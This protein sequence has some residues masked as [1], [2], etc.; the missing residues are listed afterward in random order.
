V[1]LRRPLRAWMPFAGLSV[2]LVIALIVSASGNVMRRD[3]VLRAP[4]QGAVALLRAPHR[5]CQGP[6]MAGASTQGVAI[7]G[8][9][10]VGPARVTV[11]VEDARSGASLATGHITATGTGQYVADLARSV[12]AGRR[13]RVCL[14]TTLNT[15]ELL[16][17]PAADPHVVMTG[18]KRGLEFSLALLNDRH[19]LLGS[20][21]TAFS[22]AA[23]FKP[24]W[25]GGWTFWVL[26]VALLATFGLAGFAIATA[27]SDD[28][29]REP[30]ASTDGV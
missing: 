1:R 15:F 9:S 7:W 27:A 20:L 21:S 12:P 29:E 13:L 10:V 18:P 2:I 4:D 24:S 22:R 28:E 6:I 16:G 17:A 3:F 19:S 23:L 26:T 11:D 5:V 25:V 14:T 30:R 8:G